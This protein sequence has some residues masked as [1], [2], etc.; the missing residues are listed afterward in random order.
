M[1]I[2]PAAIHPERNFLTA[3]RYTR[4]RKPLHRIIRSPFLSTQRFTTAR[5]KTLA[6]GNLLSNRE[7]SRNCPATIRDWQTCRR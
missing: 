1:H 6:G 3:I 2:A 4:L 7:T 5:A